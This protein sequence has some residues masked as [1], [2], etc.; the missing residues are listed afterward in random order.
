MLT[1]LARHV[2]ADPRVEW[3]AR[4][5]VDRDRLEVVAVIQAGADSIVV[6]IL[7]DSELRGL[8]GEAPGQD[9][10]GWTCAECSRRNDRGRS[11]CRWCSAHA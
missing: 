1:V 7:T 4:R 6:P 2:T 5:S 9:A 11:W 8:L 3:Q 10:A